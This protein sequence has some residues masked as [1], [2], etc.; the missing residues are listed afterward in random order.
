VLPLEMP[1]NSVC[2][3][4]AEVTSPAGATAVLTCGSDDGI[5][6]WL[7]GKPVHSNDVDRGCKPDADVV[8][9]PLRQGTNVLLFKVNNRGDGSGVQARVR[10]RPAEFEVD[11]LAAAAAEKIKGDGTRGRAVFES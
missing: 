8:P 7:D 9:V 4:T 5:K 11:Q 10:T 1:P 3:L 2:Y 6:V